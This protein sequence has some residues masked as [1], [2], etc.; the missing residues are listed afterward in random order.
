MIDRYTYINVKVPPDEP[1]FILRGQDAIAADMVEKW[2]I[3]ARA[4]GCNNDKVQEAF[5]IAEEMRRWHTRKIP[6]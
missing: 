2:T 4:L 5:A 3:H 6:D 1:I